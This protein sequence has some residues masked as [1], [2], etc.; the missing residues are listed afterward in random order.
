M[1]NHGW[2][3]R[4]LKARGVSRREFVKFCASM[5]AILALPPPVAAKLA[6]TVE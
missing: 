5:A 2:L 3:T 4:E 6:D 1:G